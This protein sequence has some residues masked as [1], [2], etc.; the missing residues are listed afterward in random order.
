M[1]QLRYC[2]VAPEHVLPLMHCLVLSCRPPPH[3][4]EQPLQL[5]HA[6]QL[7]ETALGESVMHT[8]IDCCWNAFFITHRAKTL[9]NEMKFPEINADLS[10]TVCC[11]KPGGSCYQDSCCLPDMCVSGSEFLRCMSCCRCSTIPTCS[12]WQSRLGGGG[13]GG[14]EDSK[15]SYSTI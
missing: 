1:L 8:I 13:G 3:V 4:R 11:R 5:P 2:V 6:D 10:R 7:A 9:R 15:H 14:D 12:S